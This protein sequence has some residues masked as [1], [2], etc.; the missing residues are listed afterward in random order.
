[1]SRFLATSRRLALG[2]AAFALVA[3]FNA[4]AR[5]E[6]GYAFAEETISNLTAAG[7]GDTGGTVT[8]VGT[9]PS[10]QASAS[11]DGDGIARNG[12][13]TAHAELG[14]I[15]ASL[16]N[17]LLPTTFLKFA[18]FSPPSPPT[19]ATGP[20]A[21]VPTGGPSFTRGAVALVGLTGQAVAE[22]YIN[23]TLSSGS[24]S[25]GNV[26]GFDVTVSKTN[27]YDINFNYANDAYAFVS[28]TGPGNSASGRFSFQI[29]IKDPTGAVIFTSTPVGSTGVAT[30]GQA[31]APPNGPEIL[32]TNGTATVVTPTLTQGLKYTVV[33]S[34]NAATDVKVAA[35][36]EPA[37]MA[38]ALTALPLVGLGL[39][40]RR[41]RKAQA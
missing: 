7:T 37:T 36:P 10:S 32:N 18:T 24:G 8:V 20:P 29:Q 40:R 25:G 39:L 27:T 3:G 5:A 11:L 28:N 15:P 30:N 6:I 9:N 2:V 22:T 12:T 1:M 17:P 38:M 31:F 13:T 26:L 35:V 34:L 4:A 23:G 21:T 16:N 41:N 19:P 14:L 33:F